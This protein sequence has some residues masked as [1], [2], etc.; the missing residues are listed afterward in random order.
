MRS[1]STEAT[2]AITA[3]MRDDGIANGVHRAHTSHGGVKRMHRV[4]K[5]RSV[6]SIHFL[7]GQRHGW[8]VLDN[9][10][11][12]GFLS[13]PFGGDGVVV[14]VEKIEHFHKLLLVKFTCFKAWQFDVILWHGWAEV[15]QAPNGSRVTTHLEGLG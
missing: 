9:I 11:A 6:Y 5:I 8:R 14:L 1:D 15:T 4:L 3:T 13:E 10:A 12:T 2:L 7:G